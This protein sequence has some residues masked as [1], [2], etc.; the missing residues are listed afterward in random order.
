MKKIIAIVLSL[1]LSTALFSPASA[2]DTNSLSEDSAA[3]AMLSALN[4]ISLGSDGE[5]DLDDTLTRAEFASII[6]K[7]LGIFSDMS[8]DSFTSYFNDVTP[9]N[10]YLNDI[11]TA[12]DLGILNG[13]GNGDF[14]PDDAINYEQVLKVLV[15]ATGYETRGESM[16]GYPVGYMSAAKGIGIIGRTEGVFGMPVKR[17]TALE[18]IFNAMRADMQRQTEFG[19]KAVFSVEKGVNLLTEKHDIYRSEGVLNATA[20]TTFAGKSSLRADEVRVEQDIYKIGNTNAKEFLGYMVT[21]YGRYDNTSGDTELI[22]IHTRPGTNT[23]LTILPEK[24]H[25]DTN[26]QTFVYLNERYNAQKINLSPSIHMI[27]NGRAKLSFTEED[28]KPN[29]GKV[30]LVDNN[31]DGIYDVVLVTSYIDYVVDA[32]DSIYHRIFD[33]YGKSPLELDPRNTDINFY[34]TQN[35]GSVDLA[36]IKPWDV[37]SV[38]AD[39][40][41]VVNGVRRVDTDNAEVYNIIVSRQIIQGAVTEVR[42]EHVSINDREYKLS[43]NFK[44]LV[45]DGKLASPRPGSEGAFY[46]NVNDEITAFSAELSGMFR[47]GYLIDAKLTARLGAHLDMK[48]LDM[49]GEILIT[50]SRESIRIGDAQVNAAAVLSNFLMV[51]GVVE[52]QLLGYRL[53]SDGDVSELIFAQPQT[54]YGVENDKL[55]RSARH[56]NSFFKYGTWVVEK[57]FSFDSSNLKVFVVPDPSRTYQNAKGE[58]ITPEDTDYNV[59]DITYLMGD[60]HYDIV[61]YNLS[62]VKQCSLAVVYAAPLLSADADSRGTNPFSRHLRYTVVDKVNTILNDEGEE[63]V[64]L[65][66]FT[67]GISDE[68][69]FASAE[70]YDTI[71]KNDAQ[72]NAT[73][74]HPLSRGDIVTYETNKNGEIIRLKRWFRPTD[75]ALANPVSYNWTFGPNPGTNDDFRLEYG[76]VQRL[77]NDILLLNQSAG[78]LD[79]DILTMSVFPGV[80]RANFI[81]VDRKRDTVRSSSIAEI[82]D[83]VSTGSVD[84]ATR[85]VL[86]VRQTELWTVI[87]YK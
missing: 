59:G 79:N 57:S 33:K 18:L 34:I 47:H 65:Y 55:L 71:L 53:N 5:Y 43:A 41:I 13:Y 82:S 36:D 21:L 51:S 61:P 9:D 50:K 49:D 84:T 80:S 30:V 22:Y 52:P 62:E 60:N 83:F 35:G 11:N 19:N 8:L 73:E 27:F 58:T 68:K 67:Q 54:T 7:A 24:I 28:L 48:I 10:F 85:A 75:E 76:M 16:G 26:K 46:I 37:L 40:E 32:A 39:K 14:G 29:A 78:F 70:L 12:V 72:F 64:K 4:I 25:S 42:D 74:I 15:C 69:V 23:E 31:N 6:L 17:G 86:Q 77:S 44:Q 20:D 56:P 87:I 81:L 45:A 3:I 63:A 2:A 66:G 38:A 1:V